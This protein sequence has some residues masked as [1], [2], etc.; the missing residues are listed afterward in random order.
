MLYGTWKYTYCWNSTKNLER[1]L[2][3][4]SLSFCGNLEKIPYLKSLFLLI[5]I[6]VSMAQHWVKSGIVN[7]KSQTE[8]GLR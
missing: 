5:T 7:L 1:T 8:K 3:V 6:I 2:I 4:Y